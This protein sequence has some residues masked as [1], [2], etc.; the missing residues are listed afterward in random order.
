MAIAGTLVVGIVIGAQIANNQTGSTK[1]LEGVV[2]QIKPDCGETLILEKDGT[3]STEGP[4]QCDGGGYITIKGVEIQFQS[5]Y[6]IADEAFSVDLGD[7][8]PGD[9][10][11]ATYKKTDYNNTF[12]CDTC[13][14][15]KL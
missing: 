15:E 12:D 7:I 13:K 8:K 2:T 11:K 4:V 1:S 14:I 9:I 10:V 3:V 5:G 6:V